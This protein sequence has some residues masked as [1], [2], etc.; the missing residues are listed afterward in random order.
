[1]SYLIINKSFKAPWDSIVF[2]EKHG[3]IS[4]AIIYKEPLPEGGR[5]HNIKVVY[6]MNPQ[7]VKAILL[8]N[9][10]NIQN[11]LNGLQSV[12]TAVSFGKPIIDTYGQRAEPKEDL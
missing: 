6:N 8:K 2:T 10:W 3:R 4:N 7:L 1:M 5:R 9:K 12:I 11:K